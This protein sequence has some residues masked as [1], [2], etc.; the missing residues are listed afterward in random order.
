VAH[1]VSFSVQAGEFWGIVGENGS[2]KTTLMKAL[3]G[4]IPCAS[5]RIV[6]GEGLKPAEIGYLPQQSAIQKDFPAS[7]EEVVL[8][9]TIGYR[10]LKP[11]YGRAERALANKNMDMLGLL[12]LKKRCYQ[13]LS[14]GQQ[15]VL[16]A[17]ALC[18]TKKC[19]V[20]DEPTTGLDPVVTA[21]FY[22]VLHEINQS[23]MTIIMVSHDVE[24]AVRCCTHI[25][26]LSCHPLF[27]GTAAQYKASP[28]GRKYLEVHAL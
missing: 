7:V 25:L 23:G 28:L 11:F 9:G 27:I 20:L 5:G 4:L 16:L 18:A 12:P 26:H 1:D 2:G 22:H 19:L 8:S 21:E 6:M 14:G 10:G 3:L 13:E 15:R 24:Q 17:R